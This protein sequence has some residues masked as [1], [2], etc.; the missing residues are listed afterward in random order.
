MRGYF[1]SI[2]GPDSVWEGTRV[3]SRTLQPARVHF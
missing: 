2:A 3:Y 1:D